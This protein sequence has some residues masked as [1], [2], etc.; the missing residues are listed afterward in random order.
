MNNVLF[1]H[2][3]ESMWE[4]GM[5]KF[6]A[7]L[8]G[9]T[10]KVID[11][12]ENTDIDKVILTRFEENEFGDEHYPIIRY[13]QENNI[14]IELN[15]YAY[16]LGIEDEDERIARYPLETENDDWCQGTRDTHDETYILDIDPFHKD[17][18]HF[19]KV[20]LA[21]AFEGECVL[22]QEAIFDAID[23]NYE[24]VEGLVVGDC[25]EYQFQS[26]RISE[27]LE[28]MVEK[29]ENEMKAI[30]E[31]SL[32]SEFSELAAIDPDEVERIIDD[33]KS[34]LEDE[35]ERL[36][37]SCISINSCFQEFSEVLEGILVQDEYN[38]DEIIEK[39][40]E[41]RTLKDN[42]QRIE[43]STY[44]H[45]THWKK[46]TKEDNFSHDEINIDHND[47][48]AVYFSNAEEV[49]S[50]FAE[51]ILKSSTYEGEIPV[52]FKLNIEIEKGYVHDSNDTDIRVFDEDLSLD[53]REDLYRT[54]DNNGYDAFII[55]NNYPEGS[56][57]AYLKDV[58]SVDEAK[59]YINNK[60]TD[61]MSV[62]D[63]KDAVI[64]DSLTNKNKSKSK[65]RRSM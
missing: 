57:V 39:I 63:L 56:D 65:P 54:F 22:D 25:C 44:Y 9:Q 40:E 37:G 16:P 7:T 6:D 34:D 41:A 3:F 47:N 53:D 62:D 8:E 14:R 29:Y 51:R 10:E 21:G 43:E 28:E 42:T 46:P 64:K 30:S 36:E 60:W 20:Y 26:K 4:E 18:K 58:D 17:L 38:Y 52:I 23:I 11:F 12:L 55:P 1:L 59:A 31:D 45:G 61:Y 13:C 5:R 35:S 48:D 27:V 24:K 19:D 49:A 33:L 32:C 2:H 15:V 50:T